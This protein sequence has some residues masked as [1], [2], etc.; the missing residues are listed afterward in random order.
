MTTWQI[1]RNNLRKHGAHNDHSISLNYPSKTRGYGLV[2]RALTV[3]APEYRKTQMQVAKLIGRPIHVTDRWTEH[4]IKPVS[5]FSTHGA[6]ATLSN[7]KL[8]EKRNGIWSLTKLG[9]EYIS[10]MNLA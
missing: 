5:Y 8:I 6:W 4:G 7:A 2:L 9:E 3:L 10:A 1:A